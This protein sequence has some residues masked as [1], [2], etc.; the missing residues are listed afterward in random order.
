MLETPG[1]DKKEKTIIQGEDEEAQAAEPAD[2][3]PS[4][5]DDEPETK[6]D[7]FPSITIS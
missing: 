4:I 5:K 6:D 7:D 1:E 2:I 3:E